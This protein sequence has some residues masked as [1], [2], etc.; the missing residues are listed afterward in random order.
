MPELIK[1]SRRGFITGLAALVA[2]PA[3]V[4]ASSLM[5]VRSIASLGAI[6]YQVMDLGHFVAVPIRF[7]INESI[8]MIQIQ[9][10]SREL[11]PFT[12]G[13]IRYE[14]REIA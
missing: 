9:G 3:I 6:E 5:P 1:P 4:R 2:A 8:T 11:S 14:G 12:A 10:I 7:V 13:Q